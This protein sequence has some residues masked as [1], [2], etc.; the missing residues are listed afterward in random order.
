MNTER[1]KFLTEAMGIK[2]SSNNYRVEITWPF[3]NGSIAFRGSKEKC[4]EYADRHKE[5]GY[6]GDIL[7]I[8]PVNQRKAI[9][10]STWEGFGKLWEWTQEQDWFDLFQC[11]IYYHDYRKHNYHKGD[12]KL[13]NDE[14]L[15]NVLV[16][17]TNFANAVYEFLKER[18]S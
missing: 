1:D 7:A 2:L 13:D 8:V 6:A 5:K 3:P 15:R 9:D 14:V 17:P 12:E 10:F 16:N 11:E 4:H 18:Q